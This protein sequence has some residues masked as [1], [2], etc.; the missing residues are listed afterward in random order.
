MTKKDLLDFMG[1]VLKETE[2]PASKSIPELNSDLTNKLARIKTLVSLQTS[3]INED[4]QYKPFLK[5]A[6]VIILMDDENENELDQSIFAE[7]LKL[8]RDY[9]EIE[10][11]FLRTIRTFQLS[12]TGSQDMSKIWEWL[13]SDKL[14][15][16]ENTVLK[17]INTTIYEIGT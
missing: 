3:M 12:I 16:I 2:A 8:C 9:P 5:A 10:A 1:V 17:E 7:K 11:F 14:K 15:A 4:F 13:P 6:C